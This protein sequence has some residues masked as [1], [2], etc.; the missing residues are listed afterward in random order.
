NRSLMRPPGLFGDG[1]TA[2]PQS[3]HSARAPE[4]FTTLVHFS[5]SSAM[6][7]AKSADEPGSTIPPMAAIFAAT[8]GSAR[9][10]L[11]SRLSSSMIALGVHVGAP[12]PAQ[13]LVS[14]PGTKSATVGTSGNAGQRVVDVT[15]SARSLPALT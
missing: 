13:A 5:V 4:N 3:S 7:L 6:N 8:L 14:K 2:F 15:P 9:P 11:I 1:A 12:K 10:A